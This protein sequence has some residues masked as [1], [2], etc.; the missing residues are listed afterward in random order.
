MTAA[1]H[2]TKPLENILHERGHPYMNIGSRRSE[3][4]SLPSS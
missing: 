2:T 3:L 1:D 4:A